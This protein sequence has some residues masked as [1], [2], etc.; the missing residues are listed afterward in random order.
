MLAPFTEEGEGVEIG[1]VSEG[2]PGEETKGNQPAGHAALPVAAGNGGIEAFEIVDRGFALA[3]GHHLGHGG[4]LLAETIAQLMQPF[5]IPQ[6][7]HHACTHA[8][9]PPLR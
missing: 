9:E 4:H 8:L 1:D 5:A 2:E 7:H 3:D 6:N